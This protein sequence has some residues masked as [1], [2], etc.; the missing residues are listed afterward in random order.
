MAQRW[1][2]LLFAHW[3]VPAPML[4]GRLPAGLEVDRYDGSAWLGV[5]PFSMDRVRSR[6]AG[7]L[8]LGVPGAKAFPELNL[9]TYVRS[10]RTG[11]GGGY[12][13]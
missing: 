12:F 13:F 7:G 5:V 8:E 9:R 1:N 3:P 4:D 11:L 6:I 10:R 2:D